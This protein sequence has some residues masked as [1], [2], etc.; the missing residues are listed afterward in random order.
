[1]A[2]DADTQRRWA[3]EDRPPGRSST[4]EA[5]RRWD[6][7]DVRVLTSAALGVAVAETRVKIEQDSFNTTVEITVTP[8]WVAV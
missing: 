5:R 7:E 1:M 3:T 8:G 2:V 6:V 4:V